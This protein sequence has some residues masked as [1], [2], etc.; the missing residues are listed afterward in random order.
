[1][2]EYVTLD[3]AARL[4]E[5]QYKT[6]AKRL[7]RKDKKYLIK[8]ETSEIGGK[9]RVLILVSSLSRKAQESYRHMQE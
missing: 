3:E 2:E 7:E 8:N 1:M 9:E 4:E 5:V 6:F